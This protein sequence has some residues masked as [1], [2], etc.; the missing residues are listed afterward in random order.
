MNQMPD[1]EQSK[2]LDAAKEVV[3]REAFNMQ[4]YQ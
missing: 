2:Y 4:R 3:K 1:A